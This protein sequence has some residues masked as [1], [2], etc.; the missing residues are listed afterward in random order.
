MPSNK[1]VLTIYPNPATDILNI[2]KEVEYSVYSY[3]GQK[4]LK[5]FGK[6]IDVTKLSIGTYVLKTNNGDS[7]FTVVR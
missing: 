3:S 6:E 2:S 7:K 1:E 4:I 5:G